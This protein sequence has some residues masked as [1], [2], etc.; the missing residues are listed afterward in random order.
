MTPKPALEAMNDLYQNELRILQNLL[1]S[2]KLLEKLASA[3]NSNAAMINPALRLIDSYIAPKL[4]P[5]KSR[6][7]KTSA[8]PSTP[9][10]WLKASSK[11]LSPF[12]SWLTVASL[13]TRPHNQ[14]PNP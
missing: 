11:S 7:L 1:P 3:L 4:I 13:Q 14:A 6:S 12:T 2:M 8:S 5:S 9:L 10:P